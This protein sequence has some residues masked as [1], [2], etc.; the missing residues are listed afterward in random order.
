L[1]TGIVQEVGKLK[2][3]MS[4]SKKYQLVIEGREVLNNVSKGDSIAVN[5]VCL[6][7]VNYTEKS[8]TADVM[9]ETLKATNLSNLKKGSDI[10]LEQ[11]VQPDGFFGGHLVT[12]HVDGIG[13][14]K[15]IRSEE[16]ARIVQISA[17][18]RLTDYMVDKGSVALNGVSLT[19]VKM[20][21]NSL[22]VSLIPETWSHT[23]FE[24]LTIG[25]QIN[26]ETDLLGKYVVKMMKKWQNSDQSKSNIDKDFL[27]QNGFI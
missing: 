3:R 24:N 15:D 11:S 12:G 16:N 19:I 5:G 23:N 6:T 25:D 1:F 10:N 17:E 8:F 27:S 20:E 2:D 7:V 26:V 18:E 13:R 14:V 22:T 21:P 4:T 9:P